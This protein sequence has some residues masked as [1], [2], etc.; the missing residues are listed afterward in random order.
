[1][2]L[3][4][5][6]VLKGKIKSTMQ[7]D[8]KD[9]T[10]HYEVHIK[11]EEE[12]FRIAINI[13]SGA[14]PSEVL[15]FVSEDFNSEDITIL[16]TL[17]YGFTPINK[18]NRDIALDY[19]RGGLFNPCKMIPLIPIKDGVDNDLNEKVHKYMTEASEK[20]GI[21]YAFG[22]KFS[23]KNKKDRYFGFFPA[24]GIHDIH[25][26]QGN[27]KKWEEDDGIWQ[28]GGILIHFEAEKRWVGIFLA[29]QSQSWCTNNSGHAT[30]S[31][32]ECNH[33]STSLCKITS[34]N[35]D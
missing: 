24:K 7:G 17:D 13:K 27:D 8:D 14:K 30:K 4:N 3:K 12:D 15:Y 28:D 25:M 9:K 26:N 5:Y 19:I 34:Q 20:D 23:D 16:P 10:P 31:V 35:D 33:M 22:D 11:A 18:D 21:V 32:K 29:F 1:M 2:A 6:G